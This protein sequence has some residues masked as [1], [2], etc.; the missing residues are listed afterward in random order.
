[1]RE[2]LVAAGICR[3]RL[4]RLRPEPCPELAEGMTAETIKTTGMPFN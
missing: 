1:M 3:H 4:F 2:S